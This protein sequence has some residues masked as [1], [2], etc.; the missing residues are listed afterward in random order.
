[1]AMIKRYQMK[2]RIIGKGRY[3]IL[4]K[5]F[6]KNNG[7]KG[8]LI[9]RNKKKRI[10]EFIKIKTCKKILNIGLLITRDICNISNMFKECGSLISIESP[11]SDKIDYIELF[12]NYEF[13]KELEKENMFY[14]ENKLEEKVCSMYK[15]LE[16]DI[17][18]DC[19]EISKCVDDSS[20]L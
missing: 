12:N 8:K 18:I 7:N 13:P 20:N 4:G 1:M 3:R 10:G 17:N 9:I 15:G 14:S 16:D 6:V 19:S 2:Y 5:D 11:I